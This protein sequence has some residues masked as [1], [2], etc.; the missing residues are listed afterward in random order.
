MLHP[1]HHPSHIHD[2]VHLHSA[3]TTAR[4]NSLQVTQ[5][6][7]LCAVT[8]LLAV[9]FVLVRPMLTSFAVVLSLGLLGLHLRSQPSQ[10]SRFW[11]RSD[12]GHNIS[13]HRPQGI[14]QG[15]SSLHAEHILDDVVASISAPERKAG[16]AKRVR[17]LS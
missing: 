1:P 12:H 14:L 5:L 3:N 2:H 9:F 11:R 13:G 7:A 16:K 10:S 17:F 8:A 4:R 6:Q 15:S